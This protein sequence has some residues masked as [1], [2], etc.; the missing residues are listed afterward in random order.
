MKALNYSLAFVVGLSL[1]T[2]CSDGNFVNNDVGWADTPSLQSISGSYSRIIAV[3]DYLY[4][5]DQTNIIT[6]DIANRDNP[7]EVGRSEIGLAV[8]TIYHH[9][10]NLFIGSREGMFVYSIQADGQPRRRGSYDYAQLVGDVMPCD[11]VVA[12]DRTAFATLY[13]SPGSDECGRQTNMQLLVTMDVSNLDR[14]VLVNSMPVTTP[15]GLSL[16]GNLL[17]VCND[18]NGF[19]VYDISDRTN[20]R[21]LSQVQGIMSWDAVA[22]DGVLIV[23]GNKELVQFDYSDPTQLVELSRLPFNR[24]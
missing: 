1:F 7:Q 5:V 22:N 17:F 2:A 10:G 4:A 11:P 9:D 18:V 3:G 20:L 19:T 15:R 8:E 16:D 14:P 24:S 23:V 21:V 12:N 13:D 6:Y